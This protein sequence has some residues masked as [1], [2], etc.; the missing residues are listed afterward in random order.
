[1]F[2]NIIAKLPKKYVDRRKIRIRSELCCSTVTAN[3][4]ERNY[5]STQRSIQK[6]DIGNMGIISLNR[7]AKLNSM[8]W[9]MAI[10]MCKILEE[11]EKSKTHVIW[12]SNV[13]NIF[14][15]GG[16]VKALHF[17]SG[18]DPGTRFG[19][20]MTKCLHKLCYFVA[21]YQKPLITIMNGLSFGGV[22]GIAINSKFTVATENTIYATPETSVGSTPDVGNLYKLSK[23]DKNVGLYLGLTGNQLEGSDV[24]L[25]GLTTHFIPSSRMHL[26]T[27][28]LTESN[29]S[30]ISEILKQHQMKNLPNQSSLEP[31]V[32]KINH[33]FS[34]PTVEEIIDRLKNDNSDWSKN[35]IK[36]L[37]K[38]S[39]TALK[40]TKRAFDIARGKSF[41]ECLK[42]EFGLSYA[43]IH[44]DFGEGIRARLVDK[45]NK[46]NWQPKTLNEVSEDYINQLFSIVPDY[47]QL[48]L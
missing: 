10:Y 11:W 15:V 19:I 44:T 14:S 48:E 29:G 5:D 33:C 31:F 26:L 38:N 17:M 18:L 24:C 40:M 47:D 25:A 46:P 42:I 34:A 39:P 27:K 41:A 7:P 36:T 43:A 8:N 3:P 16:D 6:Q 4:G 13:K 9:S 28:E 21:N 32:E 22:C 2:K 30:D 20:E 1:M 37:A 35:V 12:K 23:V 45:D